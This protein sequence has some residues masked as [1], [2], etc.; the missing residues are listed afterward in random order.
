MDSDRPWGKQLADVAFVSDPTKPSSPGTNDNMVISEKVLDSSR[1]DVNA[2]VFSAIS[3]KLQAI[4]VEMGFTLKRTSRSLYV[5]DGEDF[6]AAIVG[7][8]GLILAA[9][10]T[11]GTTLLTLVNSSAAISA[12]GGLGPGDVL[13]TNDAYTSGALSTHLADIHVIEPY[14]YGDELVGYGWAFI[15]SSDV[16]GRVP[17]SIS[18][19]NTDVYQEGLQI[20]PVKLVKAGVIDAE[21]EAF[22][23]ANSRTPDANSADI[24]AMLAALRH[25]KHA[26]NSLIDKYGIDAFLA[27][28]QRVLARS[29]ERSRQIVKSLPAGSYSFSDFLDD[30]GVS[31]HPVRFKVTLTID[32]S[33]EL[34]VDFTGTD[35]QVGSAFN[36]VS[37]GLP[38]PMTTGRVRSAFS[39]IDEHFPTD[40][41]QVRALRVTAPEGSVV[42]ALRPAAVGARHVSG[43][44][45]SDVLGGAFLTIAPQV[46]PA[47]GSGVVIPVVVAERRGNGRSSQVATTLFGGFGAAYGL[48]GHDG[49][50]NSYSV[51]AS[52]SME[53]AEAELSIHVVSYRLLPDSGGAGRWRGGVGRELIFRVDAD[54]TQVLARGLDRFVFRPWGVFGGAPGQ[55]TEVIYNEG[56]SNERRHRK[57]DV[58]EL[59]RG[60]TMTFRTPGG[61]GY[62]PAHE[63]DPDLILK[64]V[65]LGLV[66]P[67]RA[68]SDYGLALVEAGVDNWAVDQTETARLRLELAARDASHTHLFS[69]GPERTAWD[70][71]FSSAWYDEFNEALFALP[72]G[73]RSARRSELFV[74]VL[75]CL[76]NDFPA[77][78]AD[79]DQ[80]ER[81]KAAAARLLNDLKLK[82]VTRSDELAGR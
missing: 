16:G 12:V 17:S 71:V 32:D 72:A 43:V 28:Q 21:I 31:P 42:D 47:A 82:A 19:L 80:I 73:I 49:K 7:L 64:D 76:P 66:S 51:V 9:P 8:D 34:G 50:D 59:S 48:D 3:A 38:N 58:L 29:E 57:I 37:A 41:G 68:R 36:I 11:V 74:E 62:G 63:R 24:R 26:V 69:Y 33:G 23:R 2:V 60:D 61:G 4:A 6:C 1:H 78:P 10:D 30:D 44:R 54:G 70:S 27:T 81:G 52:N 67:A 65:R 55:P 45:L 13:I 15:H 75:S 18:P 35:P 53:S 56:R 46:M 79:P 39:T 40:G 25:G 22:V 77:A 14:Y 20:P 5:K